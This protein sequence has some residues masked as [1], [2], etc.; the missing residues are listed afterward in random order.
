MDD[1]CSTAHSPSSAWRDG[2]RRDA[3]GREKDGGR[4]KKKAK[5]GKSALV[6]EEK[7][8]GREGRRVMGRGKLTLQN[9][10]LMGAG[11]RL[12]GFPSSLFP[13]QFGFTN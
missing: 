12:S 6:V 5:G 2:G 4:E 10:S 1:G 3:T 8:G 13:A 7:G 9:G 11:P